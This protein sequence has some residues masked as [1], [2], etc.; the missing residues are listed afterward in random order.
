[1]CDQCE[2]LETGRAEV[3][4]AYSR[5]VRHDG[6]PT[7]KMTCDEVFEVCDRKWRGIGLI[8]SKTPNR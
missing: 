4:N 8:P 6:N 5:V 7:R 2:Q 1:M 3:E